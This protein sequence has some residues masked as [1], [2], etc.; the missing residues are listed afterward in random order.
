[1]QFFASFLIR[2]RHL[3]T[4]DSQFSS[5]CCC[6]CNSILLTSLWKFSISFVFFEIFFFFLSPL[7]HEE[8]NLLLFLEEVGPWDLLLLLC[9]AAAG[10]S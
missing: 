2:C 1:V 4:C 5:N 6:S 7:L 10:S 9:F 8:A 3:H